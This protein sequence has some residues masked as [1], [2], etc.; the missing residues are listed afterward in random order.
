MNLKTI[1]QAH[2]RLVRDS[3][4]NV[5]IDRGMGTVNMQ[6]D[7]ETFCFLQGDEGYA[8]IDEANAV[9]EQAGDMG[10]DDVLLTQVHPY[11]DLLH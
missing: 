4:I 5:E 7:G 8:F 11:L 3:G 10:W 9:W 2:A 1:L 6:C